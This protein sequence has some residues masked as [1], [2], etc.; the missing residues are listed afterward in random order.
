M[1]DICSLAA[2]T[3]AFRWNGTECVAGRQRLRARPREREGKVPEVTCSIAGHHKGGLLSFLTQ[4]VH[5]TFSRR[6]LIGGIVAASIGLGFASAALA[7]LRSGMVF[8]SSNDPAGNELL[9][10]ARGDDGG[11][12]LATRMATGGLGTG[13]G[14]GSQGAVTLS[15]DGAH[16]FV[17][18]AGDDSVSTFA[19]EGAD[20]VWKSKVPSHGMHP[21]SVTEH[22]GRVYVL[23][24]G[25]DGNV[26]GFRNDHGMLQPLADGI[27]GLSQAGGTMPAQ[28][29][30]S[31][32]GDA[33]VVTEK[34]TNRLTSYRVRDD[35]SLRQPLVTASPGMTPFGFAF[36]ARNRLIVSEAAGGA[37]GASSVSSYRFSNV[38]P[39]L[40]QVVS[41]AVP[42]AQ[43][44][45]CW[46]AVTPGGHFAYI[47]NTGSSNVSSYHVAPDGSLSLQE[48]VAGTTGEGS[49]PADLVVSADGHH[50]YV[51]NGTTGTISSFK[52]RDDGTLAQRPLTA[53]LSP[54]AAGLAA[55]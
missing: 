7:G 13:A 17:V 46:V 9:V 15:R 10:Y 29:S 11:L 28:V 47:A 24:D 20:L 16:V 30:F 3:V 38:D 33:L 36:N 35:F 31:T 19:L 1:D 51:R 27:R 2:R 37:P 41:A 12:V 22:H 32:D 50:L 53:G 43:T 44:A 52:V 54:N 23:N 26:A 18:N 45:A 34:A 40:P 49:A 8:T 48:A 42:S 25:G 4:G 14:L 5:M 6:T 39:Q 21:I 55:N